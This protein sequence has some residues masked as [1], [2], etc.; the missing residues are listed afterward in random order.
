MLRQLQHLPRCPSAS[1]S[2]ALCAAGPSSALRTGLFVGSL[3]CLATTSKP[4]L[5]KRK[6]EKKPGTNPRQ[7]EQT[8]YDKMRQLKKLWDE[9]TLDDA[10]DELKQ[11]PL[12]KQDIVTW[13]TMIQRAMTDKRYKLAYSMYNEMKRRG[14]HPNVRTYGTMLSGYATID[15]WTNH[16]QTASCL[17]SVFQAYEE[18]ASKLK[19]SPLE[20]QETNVIPV[21]NYL[22][23]L[24]HMGDFDRMWQIFNAMPPTGPG[25]ATAFT[26]ATILSRIAERRA[27]VD[28]NALEPE[29]DVNAPGATARAA[30]P[31]ELKTYQRNGSDAL[32]VFRMMLLAIQRRPHELQ[33]DPL[34]LSFALQ[35]LLRSPSD[36]HF[37]FAQGLLQEHFGLPPSGDTVGRYKLTLSARVLHIVLS[38]LVASR[39]HEA[40]LHYGTLAMRTPRLR[41]ILD[42]GHMDDILASYAG[43]ARPAAVLPPGERPASE[44]ALAAIDWMLRAEHDVDAG[45]KPIRPTQTSYTLALRACWH[46]GDWRSACALVE[47]MSGWRADAFADAPSLEAPQPRSAGRALSPDAEVLSN[48]LRAALTTRA[49][50]HTRQALRMVHEFGRAYFYGRVPPDADVARATLRLAT[51]VVRAVEGLRNGPDGRPDQGM[52]KLRN[53]AMGYMRA[54]NV[55]VQARTLEEGPRLRR[56]ELPAR[57]ARYAP[58]AEDNEFESVARRL[59][60]ESPEM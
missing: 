32:L 24:A 39:R 36:E 29:A 4:S 5:P 47:R 27:P 10:Y 48:V 31:A 28:P 25:A 60:E 57:G 6:W 9:G 58:G 46:A 13:N 42:V 11:T 12:S 34:P 14:Y 33:M 16:T 41:K 45:A 50:A 20:E 55:P 40:C 44:D 22:M 37:H 51:L 15:D 19:G 17:H 35:N 53:A 7:K 23:C 2:A 56:G 43:V 3:R 21:N 18:Y 52:M 26:Y 54:A 59:R 38:S 8:P 30:S 49:H 1:T